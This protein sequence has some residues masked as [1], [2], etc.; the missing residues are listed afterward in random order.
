MSPPR[1]R[2]EIG[3]GSPVIRLLGDDDVEAYV[4]LRRQALDEAPLAFGASREDDVVADAGAVREQLRRTPESVI[5]GAFDERLVGCAGLYRDRHV[6]ASHKAYLWGMYVA[7]GHRRRG[8]GAGL[9][10]AVLRHATSLQDL[11]WVELSISTAA[12]DARRL[13]E[14]NGFT[15]WGTEPD[16]LRHD[17]RTASLVH[18]ARRIGA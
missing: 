16:A 7:P 4:E 2:P 12:P 1:S 11:D 15:A 17:G 13:Y 18:M 10:R 5:F 14:A 6:K 3:G 9:L 8:L